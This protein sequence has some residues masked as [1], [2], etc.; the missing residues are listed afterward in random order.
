LGVAMLSN[1]VACYAAIS[2]CS[3]D[4]PFTGILDEIAIF[5][6]ALSASEIQAIYKAGTNGMCAPTPLM[7]TGSP[8]YNKTN[9]F[10]LNASLRSSQSYHIQANTNLASTNW[11][12]LTNF[13]AGTAPIFH[14]TNK[15]ATNISKQ[16]YRIVSP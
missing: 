6:R 7:F 13:I 2:P 11:I 1:N 9:G 3:A 10:I 14:F 16:F 15:P 12:T 8:S 5:N 4:S